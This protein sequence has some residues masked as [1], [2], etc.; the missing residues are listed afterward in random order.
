MKQQ[1]ERQKGNEEPVKKCSGG[2]DKAPLLWYNNGTTSEL[3][4]GKESLMNRQANENKITALYERL[5]RDDD[6]SKVYK[7]MSIVTYP[8]TYSKS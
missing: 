2:A 6:Q 4:A 5:S 7:E 1:A 8:Q 3:A